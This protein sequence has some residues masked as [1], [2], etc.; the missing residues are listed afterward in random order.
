MSLED[1]LRVTL[2][3]RNMEIE[4]FWKRS[5]HY[6]LFVGAAL[7]A[8]GALRESEKSLNHP[9]LGLLLSCFG[10]VAS[11][12]WTINNIGSK[13]WMDD[14]ET[15]LK[16]V[17]KE[18]GEPELFKAG[19]NA[20]NKGRDLFTPIWRYSVTRPTLALSNFFMLCWLGIFVKES[21]GW[22]KWKDWE[23]LFQ[24][25]WHRKEALA[26]V[27]TVIFVICQWWLLRGKDRK[28]KD[29]D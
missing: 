27:V 16:S 4:L 10:L 1:R 2:D 28:W 11:T 7:V 9:A 12:A 21:I 18:M 22:W 24:K 19:K 13:W 26:G 15:K 29:E 17:T 14:W 3:C 20:P 23:S 25:L 6:W 5:T 8:Y